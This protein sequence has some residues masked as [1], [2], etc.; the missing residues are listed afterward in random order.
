MKLYVCTIPRSSIHFLS[1]M[2]FFF[3]ES[4]S[5]CY[6]LQMNC[7]AKSYEDVC[8]HIEAFV[9]QE[10]QAADSKRRGLRFEPGAGYAVVMCDLI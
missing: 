6:K 10:A 3:L 7:W 5:N 9:S 4:K 8:F 2:N 1:Q